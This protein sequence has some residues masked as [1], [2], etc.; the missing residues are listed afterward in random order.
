MEIKWRPILQRLVV[1]LLIQSSF[2]SIRRFCRCLLDILIT[3]Y[4]NK[5]CNM[6]EDVTELHNYLKKN[7]KIT[8]NVEDVL[9]DILV[10][11]FTFDSKLFQ[12]VLLDSTKK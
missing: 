10:V 3:H 4:I 8:V 6:A 9:P 2:V 5:K 11:S 7:S 1:T 12:G